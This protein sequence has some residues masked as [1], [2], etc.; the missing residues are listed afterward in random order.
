FATA[1]RGAAARSGQGSVRGAAEARCVCPSDGQTHRVG[2]RKTARKSYG[3]DTN[4]TIS[5]GPTKGLLDYRCG[6]SSRSR[7]DPA[8]A[9]GKVRSTRSPRTRIITPHP[10]PEVR[11]S[12]PTASRTTSS[13]S[14]LETDPA[15]QRDGPLHHGSR[16]ATDQS[17]RLRSSRRQD[18]LHG[19][20]GPLLRLK[21]LRPVAAEHLNPFH[22]VWGFG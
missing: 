1:S 4:R 6:P 20:F 22:R 18:A 13:S 12:A 14:R 16:V 19:R 2:R 5:R 21:T 10:G 11:Y 3:G 15:A 17:Y 9:P 7:P 8:R